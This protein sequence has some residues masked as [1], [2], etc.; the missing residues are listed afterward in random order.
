ML[1]RVR[2]QS[3]TEHSSSSG[4]SDLFFSA[5]SQNS[6]GGGDEGSHVPL[7][8]GKPSAQAKNPQ[9]NQKPN[10]NFSEAIEKINIRKEQEQLILDGRELLDLIKV[11]L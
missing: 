2:K 9:A 8:S 4:S 5:K 1:D 3:E 7:S 11:T 10:L 6:D